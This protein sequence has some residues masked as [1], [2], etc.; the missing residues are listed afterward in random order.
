MI[1]S[2]KSVVDEEAIA[3]AD[4]VSRRWRARSLVTACVPQ[5]RSPVFTFKQRSSPCVSMP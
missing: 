3:V 1:S 2:P 5:T 4:H